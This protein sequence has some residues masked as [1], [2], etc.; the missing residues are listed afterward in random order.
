MKKTLCFVLLAV[1]TACTST[2][3]APA[4]QT[5]KPVFT[6]SLPAAPAVAVEGMAPEDAA[7]PR[8]TTLPVGVGMTFGPSGVMLGASLD[9]NIDKMITFGPSLQ[10]SFDDDLGLLSA[11]GQ[12]KYYLPVGDKKDPTIL[13]YA[14]IGVGFASIDKQGGSSDSGMLVNVGGGVRLLTGEHYRI[15][16]EIRWNYLPDDIAGEDSYISLELVQV[17]IAF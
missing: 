12:L 10:Y 7:A 14:T 16:S 5:S 3:S 17:V 11:T 1:A 9:F 8:D 13:P 2:S 6:A 15:G 4:W